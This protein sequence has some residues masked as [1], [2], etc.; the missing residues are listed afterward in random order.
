VTA[1]VDGRVA[2]ERL[3]L[4]GVILHSSPGRFRL[5][6]SAEDLWGDALERAERALVETRG[7]REV[8]RS[9]V[10]RSVLLEFDPDTVGLPT[11]LDAV[12]E[13]GVDVHFEDDAPQNEA[14]D[15][16]QSL[17]DSIGA[18]FTSADA[19]V[20]SAL[21]GKA[22]LRTLVPVGLGVLA[23]RE[24]LAGRAAAAPWYVLAWYAF[25]SFNKLRPNN[26]SSDSS[27]A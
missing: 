12:R 17:G 20:R 16:D 23:L 15:N 19:R 6:V 4:G 26:Q 24:V 11:L 27:R 22:D 2:D 3:E 21:H 5:R 14:T 13:A 25:D 10:T 7:V 18:F 9:P 8:K 1:Q